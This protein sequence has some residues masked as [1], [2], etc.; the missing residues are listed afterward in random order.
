MSA[1]EAKTVTVTTTAQVVV[2]ADPDVDRRVHVLTYQ[3]T[4]FFGFD[5]VN[6]AKQDSG[7]P[8]PFVLPADEDLYVWTSSGT[9][10]IGIIVTKA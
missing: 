10:P 7:V 4:V 8:A 6:G 9:A 2:V 5:A 1:Y 3:N